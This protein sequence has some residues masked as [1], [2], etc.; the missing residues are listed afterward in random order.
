M[1]M[2]PRQTWQRQLRYD[3]I[4]VL[5]AAENK[6][7]PY[8]TRH[9]LLG[10]K[11]EPVH[12]VWELPQ[13]QNILK[14]QQED[15]SW[16]RAGQNKEIYPL[17]H[18]ALVETFKNFRVLVEE[19]AFT[20]HHP[21]IVKAT[22]FLFS[23]QTKEGD[24]RGFIGNQYAPY[25]TGY[26][27]SLLIMAG[28]KDDERIEKG[29]N[30][31]LSIRQIDG[32]WTIPMLTHKLDKATQNKITSEFTEPLQPDRTQPFS[33]NWTDM[34][35]RAMVVHPVYRKFQG[36]VAAGRLLKSSLFKPDHYG[37]YQD[38]AYWTRFTFW[39]PNLLTALESLRPLRFPATDPDVKKALDWFVENQQPDGLW[40]IERDKEVKDSQ[41]EE[42]LWLSLRICRMLKKYW[43]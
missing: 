11:A 13:P 6:A 34:A 26:L 41:K 21:A 37:S 40:K 33:H 4:P 36:V 8:F 24:I 20:K 15:G 12:T 35:L 29:L 32:G 43:G 25:Y 39:W 9:V 27:L 30:W 42:Q 2:T 28:Y 38:P 16:A 31:L 23:F 18:Y 14:K 19:Y 3:A 7:I 17:N 1:N 5:L 10:E 22:E